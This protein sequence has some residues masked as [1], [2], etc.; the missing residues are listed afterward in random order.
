M[1]CGSTQITKKEETT[2]VFHVSVKLLKVE[3][4]A[5]K[6]QPLKWDCCWWGIKFCAKNKN[7][8]KFEDHDLKFLFLPYDLY[9]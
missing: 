9:I 8:V 2:L 6:C 7:E 3:G 5:N 4:C 1:Q